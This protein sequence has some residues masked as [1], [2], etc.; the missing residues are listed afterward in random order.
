MFRLAIKSIIGILFLSVLGFFIFRIDQ[1]R[2]ILP[3]IYHWFTSGK[4]VFEG[5]NVERMRQQL[6]LQQLNNLIPPLDKI[7]NAASSAGNA[8]LGENDIEMCRNYYHMVLE[9]MPQMKEAHV[10]LGFCEYKAGNAQES[11][12][13]FKQGLESGAGVFGAS[14]DLGVLA[15]MNGNNDAAQVLFLQVVKLPL[16]DVMKS[17]FTSKL[18][19]QYMEVN[20][21]TPQKLLDGLSKARVNAAQNL[22][23][24]EESRKSNSAIPI[25]QETCLELF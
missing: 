11:F 13:E 22:R 2:D 21:I 15:M 24:I 7:F 16:Q 18:Y 1:Q 14:Y 9:D 12:S 6:K 5:L 3:E 20:N 10:F 19:Q 17:I 23:L 25:K 8:G 4:Y